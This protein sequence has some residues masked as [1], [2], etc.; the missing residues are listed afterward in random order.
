[1]VQSIIR[2][3]LLLSQASQPATGMDSLVARDLMDTLEANKDRCVGMA[4]NMIGINK[5]IIAVRDGTIQ[6]VMFNPVIVRQSGEFEAEEGCLSLD[7]KRK[8][9]RYQQIEVEYQDQLLRKRTGTYKGWI[10]QIIQHEIDH[11]NGKLI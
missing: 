10:A 4:A 5:R 8:T 9:I 2:D 3:P 1:M 11:C 6:F 7:G